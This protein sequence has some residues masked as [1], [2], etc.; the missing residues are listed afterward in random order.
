MTFPKNP[1]LDDALAVVQR[2][3]PVNRTLDLPPLQVKV[4]HGD[5]LVLSDQ[6]VTARLA[7]IYRV[8]GHDPA[9]AQ[10][11]TDTQLRLWVL[12]AANLLAVNQDAVP[13]FDFKAALTWLVGNIP[14]EPVMPAPDRREFELQVLGRTGWLRAALK[15]NVQRLPDQVR[16]QAAALYGPPP[17]AS[18][19]QSGPGA[20][21]GQTPPLDKE[22]LRKEL[23]PKLQNLLVNHAVQWRRQQGQERRFQRWEDLGLIARLAQAVAWQTLQPYAA[24]CGDGPFFTG[25]DYF[26]KIY[27]KT[28]TMPTEQ[29]LVKHLMNRAY[30]AG[31]DTSTG[32]SVF[33]LAGYD[34]MRSDDRLFLFE[35]LRQWITG[36]PSMRKLAVYFFQHIGSNSHADGGGVGLVTEFRTD[37]PESQS[38]WETIETI[39]HEMAHSLIHPNFRAQ[40]EKVRRPMVIKEGFIEVITR[41]VFNWMIDNRSAASTTRLMAGVEGQVVAPVRKTTL[42]YAESGAYADQIFQFVGRERFLTAFMTGDVELVGLSPS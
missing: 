6:E 17:S 2:D 25:F 14:A 5:V 16:Q 29:D 12:Y 42:G 31:E 21:S 26:S 10:K 34:S 35:M 18:T 7:S 9:L 40:V 1:T 37:R 24:A 11:L 30:V 15:A 41:E 3:Q 20:S 23:L 39:V 19:A 36:D 38:R 8:A 33:T 4:K 32:K 27:D 22:L 13:G 28:A